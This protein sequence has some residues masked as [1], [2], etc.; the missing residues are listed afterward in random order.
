MASWSD[1]SA[2]APELAD[3]IQ[4]RFAANKEVVLATLRKDGSPRV[5]GIET[6]FA[7]GEL[8]LG[9]MPQSL[10]A[11]DLQRDPRLALHSAPQD[12]ATSDGDAKINGRAVEI[13]DPA[14]FAA[15]AKASTAEGHPEPPPGPYHLFKLDVTDV[16]IVQVAGDH[17]VI[18]SWREGRGV[19][20]VK[21]Q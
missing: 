6:V 21:R 8:W 19:K 12:M 20:Q 17:L 18:D 11:L 15:V 13:T 14:T 5:S 10:K 3:R 1:L 7:L 2:D 9:M 4:R 16:S